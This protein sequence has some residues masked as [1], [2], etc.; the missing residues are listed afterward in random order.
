MEDLLIW[1]MTD[2]PDHFYVDRGALKGVWGKFIKE[3]TCAEANRPDCIY[4][5][6]NFHYEG[7]VVVRAY[8]DIYGAVKFAQSLYK[9]LDGYHNHPINNERNSKH[10]LYV[11]EDGDYTELGSTYLY[12]L[13]KTYPGYPQTQF[14]RCTLGYIIQRL[15]LN[16]CHPAT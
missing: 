4:L 7:G 3:L 16:R 10:H 8:E 14:D 2:R 5:V 12:D 1:C 15:E 6:S 11:K 9:H 13:A